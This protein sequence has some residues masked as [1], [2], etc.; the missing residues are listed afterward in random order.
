MPE[1]SDGSSGPPTFQALIILPVTFPEVIFG[2]EAADPVKV[3]SAGFVKFMGKRE[4]QIN[5]VSIILGQVTLKCFNLLN[6]KLYILLPV[7]FFE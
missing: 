2:V 5:P 4:S 1:G 3:F 7:I 6:D